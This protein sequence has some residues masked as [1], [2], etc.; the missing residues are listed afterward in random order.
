MVECYCCMCFLMSWLVFAFF[1]C[2]CVFLFVICFLLIWF[3]FRWFH[4]SVPVTGYL[5]D[6][7]LASF[8]L[9]VY[10]CGCWLG[11]LLF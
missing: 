1:V 7:L 3:E 5:I 2:F 8:G 4:L 6:V 11:G 9:F 10:V